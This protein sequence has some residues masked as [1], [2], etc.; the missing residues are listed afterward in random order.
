MS[1]RG[2]ARAKA[3]VIARMERKIQNLEVKC[4][5]LAAENRKLK[6]ELE[7]RKEKRTEKELWEES[8]AWRIKKIAEALDELAGAT[9]YAK[10]QWQE[11]FGEVVADEDR[12]D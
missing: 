9:P 11:V 4:G 12:P 2:K 10:G 8:A 1:A 7:K 6:K 5:S 3:G